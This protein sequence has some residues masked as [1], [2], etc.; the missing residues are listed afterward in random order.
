MH[1]R[2]RFGYE[3][4]QFLLGDAVSSNG[5]MAQSAVV[6]RSAQKKTVSEK[7]VSAV[8]EEIGSDPQSLEPMYSVI[9]PDALD[10]LFET[11]GFGPSRS[12]NRLSF[13]YSGCEVV[14]VGDGSVTVSTQRQE[15]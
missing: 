11:D 14:I 13:T 3:I 8:A 15:Q 9:D 5:V 6:E 1:L 4:S 10:T 7:V 2:L 12:P